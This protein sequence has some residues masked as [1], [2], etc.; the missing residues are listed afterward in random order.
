MNRNWVQDDAGRDAATV[1]VTEDADEVTVTFTEAEARAVCD[2]L[3]GPKGA[4]DGE[5]PKMLVSALSTLEEAIG[6]ARV[7]RIKAAMEDRRCHRGDTS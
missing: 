4:D 7:A 3:A 1:T 6:M 2:L 5:G